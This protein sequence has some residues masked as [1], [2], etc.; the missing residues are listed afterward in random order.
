MKSHFK[1]VP[2]YLKERNKVVL[3]LK[4]GQRVWVNTW[5]TDCDGASSQGCK[6]IKS[7]QDLIDFEEYSERQAEWADGPFGYEFI[8]NESEKAE[9]FSGVGYWGM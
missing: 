8:Y 7:V 4:K 6:E 9:S 2:Q 5:S 3:A 1:E